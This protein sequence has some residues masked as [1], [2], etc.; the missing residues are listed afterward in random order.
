MNRAA[1]KWS[2]EEY[3]TNLAKMRQEL[4]M[5]KK[6]MSDYEIRIKDLTNEVSFCQKWYLFVFSWLSLFLFVSYILFF[7]LKQTT[8]I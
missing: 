2:S 6:V 8:K 3:E 1:I 4:D 5:S 7:R